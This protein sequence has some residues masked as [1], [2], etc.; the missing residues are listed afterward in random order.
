MKRTALMMLAL[1][2]LA[3]AQPEK[4]KEPIV[5]RLEA[6]QVSDQIARQ[7]KEGAALKSGALEEEGVRL[8]QSTEVTGVMES[9]AS[10]FIGRKN[11]IIYYD[12][13]ATQFQ[14]QY[15]DVGARLNCKC[16]PVDSERLKAQLHTELSLLERNI[17]SAASSFPSTVVFTQYLDLPAFDYGA[18]VV[19]GTVQGSEAQHYL[20]LLGA[21]NAA[22]NDNVYFVLSVEKL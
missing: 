14:V 19:V 15:V 5:M 18:Y 12:A 16:K 8:L 4:K 7:W 9:E 3:W 2:T 1:S 20:H 6:V 17:P 13:R 10:T 11:P 22:N 21:N